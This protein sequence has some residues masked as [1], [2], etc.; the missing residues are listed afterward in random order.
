MNPGYVTCS[1]T[2][3]ASYGSWRAL[4][5][6]SSRIGTTNPIGQFHVA[7]ATRICPSA[8]YGSWRESLRK[9]GDSSVMSVCLPRR[10]IAEARPADSNRIPAR[11]L[12]LHPTSRTD[13]G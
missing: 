3:K 1:F 6:F 13:P 4:T 8:L 12:V 2:S 7:Y 5:T 9:G 10:H 11:E